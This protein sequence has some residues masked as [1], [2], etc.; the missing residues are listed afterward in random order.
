M[1]GR[2]VVARLRR[3]LHLS[4]RRPVDRCEVAGGL[5]HVQV[6]VQYAAHKSVFVKLN[7]QM[8]RVSV[9]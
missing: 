5:V 7:S 9:N 2:I 8:V 4:A 6:V 3:Q 1:F